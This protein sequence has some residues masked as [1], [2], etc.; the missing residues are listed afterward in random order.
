[1]IYI[2]I[3]SLIILLLNPIL[4]IL[5]Y[6][7]NLFDK[8]HSDEIFNTENN[9][10]KSFISVLIPCYNEEKNIENKI[11]NIFNLNYSKE[12]LE[13]IIGSDG[14]T[15]KTVELS[16]K[17]S[18]KYDNIKVLDLERSGKASVINKMFEFSKG[19]YILITD[20]DS[21]IIT[22]EAINIALNSSKEMI[23]SLILTKDLPGN[24]E[25]WNMDFL[26][27]KFESKFNTS[28]VASGVFMFIKR[29]YFDHIPQNIIADDLYIP[30]AVLNKKGKVFQQ[31][32]I[33]CKV[34]EEK[35]DIKNYNTKK[36]RIIKG[37]IKVYKKF[38]K[39][40]FVNN[41]KAFFFLFIHKFLRWYY[42]PLIV[43]NI[44][45]WLNYKYFLLFILILI[46]MYFIPKLKFL[47]TDLIIPLDYRIYKDDKQFKGWEKIN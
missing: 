16:V 45:L 10:S 26:I 17:L 32:R 37:G 36:R 7:N 8:K 31:D 47:I 42:L 38:W 12:K 22:N 11:K 21:E 29:T 13:I 25:Y 33:V 24:H 19:D 40:L 9:D 1:M 34:E 28:V 39:S 18:E 44:F 2:K 43:I 41:F 14:S 27:R 30:L 35:L 6:F 23:S 20:A 4:I 3:L 5:S 15:D 46:I